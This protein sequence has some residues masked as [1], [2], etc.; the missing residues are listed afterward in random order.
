[1]IEAN[2]HLSGLGLN[3]AELAGAHAIHNGFTVVPETYSMYHGEGGVRHP[4]AACVGENA[5]GRAGRGAE[6]LRGLACSTTLRRQL[7]IEQPKAEQ[8]MEVASFTCADSDTLHNM[9]L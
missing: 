7:G 4:G 1:M 9:L 8:L 3:L 2:T 6:L 5:S